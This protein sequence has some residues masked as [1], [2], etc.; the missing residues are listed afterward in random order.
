MFVVAKKRRKEKE[1]RGYLPQRLLRIPSVETEGLGG[2][3][4][5]CA[6]TQPSWAQDGGG[7]LHCQAWRP[8]PLLQSPNRPITH[9]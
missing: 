2:Q 5:V 9:C 6:S 7:G 8:G 3:Q 1:A 4:E